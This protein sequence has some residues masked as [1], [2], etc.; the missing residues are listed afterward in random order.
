MKLKWLWG[1]F[2]SFL[3]V[4]ILGLGL[5]ITALVSY[6]MGWI[7][8]LIYNHF[9][10]QLTYQVDKRSWYAFEPN[11]E[12]SHV[13]LLS[14][15]SK[16]PVLEIN[17]VHLRLNLWKSLVHLTWVM[18]SLKLSG[19]NVHLTEDASSGYRLV[20]W[21]SESSRQTSW[22]EKDLLHWFFL[23]QNLALNHVNIYRESS[24]DEPLVIK[25]LVINWIRIPPDL[26]QSHR[27]LLSFNFMF[28]DNK[29][30]AGNF[31]LTGETHKG[32]ISAFKLSLVG[33]YLSIAEQPVLN[34][35]LDKSLWGSFKARNFRIDFN[36]SNHQGIGDLIIGSLDLAPNTMFDHAWPRMSLDGRWTWTELANGD[37]EIA[38]NQLQLMTHQLIFST[39]GQLHIFKNKNWQDSWV[40]LS[41]YLKGQNIET[42]LNDYLPRT[43]LAPKLRDWLVN[44]IKSAPL[45]SSDLN[46]QG[47]FLDFPYENSKNNLEENFDLK[48]IVKNGQL[49]PWGAWPLI[50]NINGSLEFHNEKF[51]AEI[52]K[53]NSG[54][55]NISSGLIDIDNIAP[56]VASDLKVQIKLNTKD[57]GPENYLV[58]SP[59]SDQVKIFNYLSLQGPY[60]LNL[61]FLFPLAQPDKDPVYQT[62]IL[63]NQNKLILKN[64]PIEVSNLSGLVNIN[65]S[66]VNSN[67][68]QGQLWGE[69]LNIKIQTSFDDQDQKTIHVGL[70]GAMNGSDLYPAVLSGIS[71]VTTEIDL[72]PAGMNVSVKSPGIK[73]AKSFES[74]LNQQL[75]AFCQNKSDCAPVFVFKLNQ[76]DQQSL[77]IQ[78]S[79]GSGVLGASGLNLLDFSGNFLWVEKLKTWNLKQGYLRAGQAKIP[80]VIQQ[81][82]VLAVSFPVISL[83]G[84]VQMPDDVKKIPWTVNLSDVHLP[85]LTDFSNFSNS[86]NF[87]NPNIPASIASSAAGFNLTAENLK[88]LPAINFSIQNLFVN[89]RNLGKISGATSP[90]LS[91]IE[92]N[93]F[94]WQ[95]PDIN[96]TGGTSWEFNDFHLAGHI[97]GKNYGNTLK[98]LGASSFLS[99]TKGTVDFDLAWK[100]GIATPD[101]KTLEGKV[102]FNLTDGTLLNVNPGVSRLLGLFSLEAI[103]RRLSFNFQDMTGK[104]LAFNTLKGSYG[105]T[106]GVAT[107]D[108]V[109]MTGPALNL[110]LKGSINIPER[111]LDQTVLVEPQIGSSVAIV[112]AILGG[113]VAGVAVWLAD[114]VLSDTLFKNTGLLYHL[115][116]PWDKP[117]FKI[118]NQ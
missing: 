99:Q 17:H 9:Q 91:G 105:L 33:D 36:F 46:W 104:G 32:K 84:A 42:V 88:I 24:F 107:T 13:I 90:L 93:N 112:A 23:Q 64:Q 85:E 66:A 51:H 96:L 53:G 55:V 29:N 44:N 78:S 73:L 8:K 101:A 27:F 18:D 102:N 62:Q 117:E 59:I 54:A 3:L 89:G 6:Q 52:L 118:E 58:Q 87:S 1:F 16:Q 15:V 77:E 69:P 5:M 41:G 116:G 61:N 50:E 60:D 86:P 114:H 26:N 110:N 22:H 45:V 31:L 97:D 115:Y 40:N 11:L 48:I 63:F 65:G 83:D 39:Q 38:L 74:F 14:P 92:I 71:P 82:I 70:I 76:V 2:I 30:N 111:T 103:S 108:G 95:N 94:N 68:L 81:A 98:L 19:M 21:S 47:D 20:G 12:F 49:Y 80:P 4:L 43:G 79:L 57:N 75:P 106:D 109:S 67:L 34:E 72:L 37:Q 35:L 25:N 28:S 113:P 100:G 7:Q 10:H 56:G